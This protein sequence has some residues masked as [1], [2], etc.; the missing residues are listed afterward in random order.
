M[1]IGP[2]L[3]DSCP[4]NLQ[5]LSSYLFISLIN[6][7]L[8]SKC[9]LGNRDLYNED[10]APSLRDGDEF[11]FIVIGSGSAGSVV[12]NKLSEN[13]NWKVLVLEA[14]GY[15]SALSDIPGMMYYLQGT[16]EDWQYKTEPSPD[17][18]LGFKNGQCKWP[19]GKVFGGTSVFNAM[20]YI[21]GYRKDYDQ[22]AELG[23]EGWEWDT[24][25]K[26]FKDI[27]NVQDSNASD[28][29]GRN[30]FMMLTKYNS[31]LGDLAEAMREAFADLGF[32]NLEEEDPTYPMGT[33]EAYQ[34]NKEGI[35]YNAAKAFL[36][37]VKQRKNL[38][39]ALNSFVTKIL[40]DPQSKTA[41]AVEVKIG[42]RVL[43][44]KAKKEIILS[45]GAIN[46]PQILMLSGVG[47]KKDLQNL[48]INV[49]KDLPVGY[50]LE[51]HMINLGTYVTFSPKCCKEENFQ[52]ELYQYFMHQKGILSTSGIMNFWN[53]FNTRNNSQY[54]NIQNH[55]FFF[56]LNHVSFLEQL[57]EATGTKPE[58]VAGSMEI[59]RNRPTVIIGNTLMNPESKGRLLL[60]SKNPEDKPIIHSGYFTDKN[61]EDLQILL[62]SI[63]FS[64]K[65]LETPQLKKYDPQIVKL[66][67][68]EC[69]KY[70][71]R[72][73]DY[74]KC[75]LRHLT[76]TLYHPTGTCKMGP[77]D[78]GT[79]V[80]DSKLRVHGIKN[81]RVA[82]ASIMPIIA[83]ANT[84][85]PSMMIG[86]KA[87]LMITEQWSNKKTEL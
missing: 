86:F 77:L 3:V 54:P 20:L 13:K 8:S 72:S 71:Y 76:S 37:K 42:Q 15:A 84:H 81:L 56:P 83:S 52:D 44:L 21:K 68:P 26:H 23:N 38:F 6:N 79:A 78:D 45:A 73:D 34:C 53:F 87:G 30:G 17:S 60:K 35:R 58:I 25:K 51:D 80:V 64:E 41:T 46:S 70:E 2:S 16:N 57:V 39:T 19:R 67:L 63:R 10:Y 1:D 9:K 29:Y 18:C 49:L 31:V 7:L 82:D 33:L 27:E 43:K 47:P 12:S 69:D 65:L 61:G 48:Q 36:G 24:V 62:E 28:K 74:W 66:N 22:W 40:I 4:G 5:G 32:L 85:A 59:F 14:G 75:S 11:D 55:F 50:N